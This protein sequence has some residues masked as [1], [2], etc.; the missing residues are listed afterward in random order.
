MGLLNGVKKQISD[1]HEQKIDNVIKG[2]YTKFSGSSLVKTTQRPLSCKNFDEIIHHLQNKTIY[3]LKKQKIKKEY[4]W[5]KFKLSIIC[6]INNCEAQAR[7]EKVKA[8]LLEREKLL[9]ELGENSVEFPEDKMERLFEL[10]MKYGNERTI[11]YLSSVNKKLKT[12]RGKGRKVMGLYDWLEN[13]NKS[14]IKALNKNWLEAD[15]DLLYRDNLEKMCNVGEIER[16][17]ALY[18]EWKE[19]GNEIGVNELT[20][21]SPEKIKR[22]IKLELFLNNIN[23]IVSSGRLNEELRTLEQGSRTSLRKRER[24][25]TGIRE[26]EDKQ[27][28]TTE[29]GRTGKTRDQNT[30]NDKVDRGVDRLG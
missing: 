30:L 13:R 27:R 5:A 28:E 24:M 6:P 4:E 12:M 14:K 17:K 2:F 20:S 7:I 21:P 18:I 16:I 22:V 23:E 25:I 26:A 8:E 10:E 1:W 9:Y 3:T 19:L 29:V 15:F 11:K